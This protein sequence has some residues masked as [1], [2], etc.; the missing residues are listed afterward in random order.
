MVT[1]TSDG[2]IDLE[3]AGEID[4][5]EK[6]AKPETRTIL[7]RAR[8]RLK[9]RATRRGVE[10][11]DGSYVSASAARLI[12]GH[13]GAQY[14]GAELTITVQVR[15]GG[16][17]RREEPW[18]P[19]HQYAPD[20]ISDSKRTNVLEYIRLPRGEHKGKLPPESAPKQE[21]YL[22][23]NDSEAR[24]IGSTIAITALQRCHDRGTLSAAGEQILREM[25]QGDEN[26]HATKTPQS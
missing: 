25:T 19:R 22:V 26:K 21:I 7:G 23:K 6:T 17:L 24:C 11:P 5:I 13:V 16:N 9:E 8:D 20:V 18:N 1:Q 14:L 12:G 15:A 3:L 2:T 10:L 4:K